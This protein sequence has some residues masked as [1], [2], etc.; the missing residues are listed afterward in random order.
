MVYTFNGSIKTA[1]DERAVEIFDPPA[2]IEVFKGVPH[3]RL[4][5]VKAGKDR[6]R[7]HIIK[8]VRKHPWLLAVVLDEL[9]VG[10]SILGLDLAQVYTN[11]LGFRILLS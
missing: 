7:V 9:D 1:N 6:P 11:D 2:L 10:R 5:I 8:L 3:D 4:L